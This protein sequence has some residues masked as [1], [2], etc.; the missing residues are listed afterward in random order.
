[1]TFCQ[2]IVVMTELPP[3]D[4][5]CENE[6]AKP[7]QED[8]QGQLDKL[9]TEV[10]ALA[11]RFRQ[12]ARRVQISGD[13]PAGGHNVLKMLH[14]FGTLTVPQM[15]R[16]DS[17]SR[18]NIQ[19]VVNR[20]EREGC[21]GSARNP[22]HKRSELVGLTDRGVA[23]LEVISRRVDAYKEKL[24]PRLSGVELTRATELLRSIREGLSADSAPPAEN[25]ETHVGRR[26]VSDKASRARVRSSEPR[27]TGRR[28]AVLKE[29][30]SY[31]GN[32]L[33]VSLL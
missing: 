24:L 33:P 30:V 17:T 10:T 21:V 1:M 19:T 8:L 3:S 32:E 20:L 27:Q 4:I 5:S 18:Q 14:R 26:E 28:E 22:A 23:S 11:I 16:L 2:L 12:A 29:R 31:E 9:L 15:A 6:T 7:I 25:G 13:L